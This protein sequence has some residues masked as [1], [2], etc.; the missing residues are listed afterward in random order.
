MPWL[1]NHPHGWSVPCLQGREG[2]PGLGI[3]GGKCVCHAH[4][5][6][7]LCLTLPSP[8]HPAHSLMCIVYVQ[9]TQESLVTS[10]EVEERPDP[11]GRFCG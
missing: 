8:A 4:V 5:T 7:C 9:A 11:G 6:C 2:V 3:T 1:T 10:L